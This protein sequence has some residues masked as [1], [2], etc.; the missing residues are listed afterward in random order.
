ML[1]LIERDSFFLAWYAGISFQQID[2]ESIL[3]RQSRLVLARLRLLNIQVSLLDARLDV[4]VPTVIAVA[5]SDRQNGAMTVGAACSLDPVEAVRSALFEVASSIVE[6]PV[7]FAKNRAR[8]LHLFEDFRRVSTVADHSLLYAL[9]EMA[10]M[11]K[12]LDGS[13]VVKPFREIYSTDIRSYRS[14]S[15]L[16][17]LTYVSAELVRA[18]IADVVAVDLT[19]RELRKLGLRA[20]RA[21]APGLAP[22][23]FGFPENRVETLPRLRIARAKLGSKM[24]SS[25]VPIPHPFP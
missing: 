11:T 7:L 21:I 2:Q 12:W 13:N 9:S 4:D 15:L 10:D 23:D 8:A 24:V 18:G 20:A 14:D 22:I 5:R 1:E 17:D 25:S 6:L 3:D 16:G 19:T